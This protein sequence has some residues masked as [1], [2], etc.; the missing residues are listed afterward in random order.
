MIFT[1]KESPDWFNRYILNTVIDE[2]HAI[3]IYENPIRDYRDHT[4]F[5]IRA[6]L[7]FNKI[8]GISSWVYKD[9][10][11]IEINEHDRNWFLEMLRN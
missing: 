4:N 1:V 8:D 6:S 3:E 11:Y 2:L 5:L 7:Y 9:S 10:I